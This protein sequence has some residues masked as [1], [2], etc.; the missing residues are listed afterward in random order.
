MKLT[1]AKLK[2]LIKEVMT[3]GEGA[4][5]IS[6]LPDGVYISIAQ[7]PQ[8]SDGIIISYV[9]EEGGEPEGF[10]GFVIIQKPK[11]LP[12][13][14]ALMVSRASA[15]HGYGPLLYDIAMEIAT[16]KGG[17]LISDRGAVSN[18][19]RDADGN[20]VLGADGKQVDGGALEVWKHYYYKRD[21][22]D[23]EGGDV[24]VIQLDDPSNILTPPKND[25]CSQDI[26]RS[27]ITG[28]YN[29]WMDSPLSKLY[30][31]QPDKLKALGK[32]LRISGIDLPGFGN[33]EDEETEQ[34]NLT[35]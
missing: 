27:T 32:K 29:T 11:D 12:C 26:A 18:T 30:R 33:Q 24:E 20:P 2:Q 10:M 14:G 8:D 17:G 28:M 15:S 31:K 16:I 4:K 22:A 23:G 34:K 5:G 7:D 25:N 13:G 35:N 9:N 3:E 19:D 1:E 6:D 21:S